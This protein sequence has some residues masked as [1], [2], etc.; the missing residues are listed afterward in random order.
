MQILSLLQ[1]RF[2]QAL[3]G[4]VENP[5]RYKQQVVEARDA[6]HGD[7][8]ANLA[9]S[10]KN[11]LSKN[12]REIAEELVERV[13]LD[14][15]C[16][17]PEIAGPGFINLKLKDE[18]LA[19]Q[20]AKLAV[21]PR[22]TVSEATDSKT[23]VIDYSSP[24]VAKPMHVGHIRTTVIGDALA[25]I[26]RFLGHKVIADNHLGD[27]GTQFGMIIY[28]Y[29]NFR[30]DA[31][32][33]QQPVAELSRIYRTVQAIVGYQAS[34]PKLPGAEAKLAEAQETL[35]VVEASPDE[36]AKQQKKKLK[37]AK[38]SVRS[39]EDSISGLNSKI[40]AVASAPELLKLAEEHPEIEKRSQL[41]TAKM[42]AGDEANLELWEKFVPISME[43]IDS[44]YRRLGVEFDH[45]YGESFY[46]PMLP[47][48]VE[49]LTESGLAKED[50]GAIC[51]FLDEFETPMIIQK[52]DGAFLYST[53]DLATIEYRMEHFKPDAILY[54][55]DHRQ[56]EHFEKL[57][58]AARKM[59]YKD[60]ELQHVSFG[61]VLGED[62][63]PF[64]T[65]SGTVMG[66]DLLLDEA[67]QAAH[68]VVCDEE[69]LEK[70]GLAELSK[71]ETL[72]IAETV[73]I[74]AIKYADLS[75]NRTSDYKFNIKEM[76]QLAGETGAYLQYM[77]ARTCS[78]IA[79]SETNLSLETVG[80]FEI[81]IAEQAE[82]DLVMK[83]L[84]FEDVLLNTVEEYYPSV[85][86][87][88]IYSLAKQFASF[89]D[90]CPVLKAET[91][92][93]KQSR[94]ALCFATQQVLKQ[95]LELLGIGV[96][97]RM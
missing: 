72:R 28:G 63:T 76:V 11:V 85:L 73:G 16:L 69:R 84:Q 46:H 49:R 44:A 80:G 75:H 43:E 82:R 4:W 15:I 55:V 83:L 67:V 30:D 3:D 7:Y 22:Q 88:Y 8:Q 92:E 12:P 74:G 59:G 81:Q 52:S 42:H 21:D 18:F 79:R 94:L 5:E 25:R 78:I 10:L 37:A 40:Q 34:L 86:T 54:V 77:Y 20:V 19:E 33:E 65:R 66:L 97:P 53:T 71:E 56:G 48:V 1:E 89:F 47:G 96:V 60:V 23:F 87:A 32:F 58:V 91:Q 14:D 93:L 61:T 51:V 45:T 36:D 70:G 13:E 50:N 68:A 9:M 31:A 39:A 17:Q 26:L 62:G 64:K 29:R 95:G 90:Q 41:E 27:W 38:R 24:N 2:S 57:F 6:R 35:A